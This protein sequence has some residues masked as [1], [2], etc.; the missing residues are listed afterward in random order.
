MVKVFPFSIALIILLAFLFGCTSETK[1]LCDQ[2]EV[3]YKTVEQP[4][5]DSISGCLCATGEPPGS[6]SKC[7]CEE[8]TYRC[9]EDPDME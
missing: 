2:R 3:S 8:V 5:C 6:C 9:R 4:G 1:N 7:T